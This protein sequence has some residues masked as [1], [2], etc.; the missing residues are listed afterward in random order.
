[1]GLFGFL[2]K[3]KEESK[4]LEL[5]SREIKSAPV[6]RIPFETKKCLATFNN[7]LAAYRL[8]VIRGRLVYLD[9][10]TNSIYLDNGKLISK[11]KDK[12]EDIAKMDNE[13]L[14][15]ATMVSLIICNVDE[16]FNLKVLYVK[17]IKWADKVKYLKDG[18]IAFI[19]TSFEEN[20]SI[21][22]KTSGLYLVRDVYSDRVSNVYLFPNGSIALQTFSNQNI[23][24]DENDGIFDFIQ[25]RRLN[26]NKNH[27]LLLVSDHY[28]LGLD[29]NSDAYTQ[30]VMQDGNLLCLG[31]TLISGEAYL[32]SAGYLKDDTFVFSFR[33]DNEDFSRVLVRK[34]TPDGNRDCLLAEFQ[35]LPKNRG[36]YVEVSSPE[37]FYVLSGDGLHHITL[38]I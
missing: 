34:I 9:K 1:M 27:A 38:K 15:I 20:L 4:D 37:S 14:V 30:Y 5:N 29:E 7:S 22:Q 2:R 13:T 12:I 24:A 17:E 25:S 6:N 33:N 28:V 31:D 35:D 10:Y 3:D 36:I 16:L 18:M 19:Q 21:I 11:G 26:L 32:Q 23:L 8:A